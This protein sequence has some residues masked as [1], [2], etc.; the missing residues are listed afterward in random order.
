MRQLIKDSI[1][2]RKFAQMGKMA[3]Q[4]EMKTW[5]CRWAISINFIFLSIRE[6]YLFMRRKSSHIAQQ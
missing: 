4:N 1:R 6:K 5:H 2:K 3:S